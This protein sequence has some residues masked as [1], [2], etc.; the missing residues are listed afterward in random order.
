MPSTSSRR[1]LVNGVP[2]N[3]LPASCNLQARGLVRL[4]ASC[5]QALTHFR[6][7]ITYQPGDRFWAFQGIETGIFVALAAV[8]IAVTAVV[9]LRRDA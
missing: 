7:F 8:L 6:F 2:V 1:S 9:L 3:L 5:S 4:P